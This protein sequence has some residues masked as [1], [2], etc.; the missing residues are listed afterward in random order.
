[1][2]RWS[3]EGKKGYSKIMIYYLKFNELLIFQK[4]PSLKGYNRNPHFPF[5]LTNNF[6]S[7]LYSTYHRINRNYPV[8]L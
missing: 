2:V 8:I 6:T 4:F 3:V 1:M 7:W 5:F